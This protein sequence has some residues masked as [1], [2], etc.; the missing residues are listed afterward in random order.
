MYILGTPRR[1]SV[2]QAKIV[3]LSPVLDGGPEPWLV[4][5]KQCGQDPWQ[6]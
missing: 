1:A 2:M 3:Q 4:P 5:F 6:F